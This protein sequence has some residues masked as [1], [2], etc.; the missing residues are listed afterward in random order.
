MGPLCAVLCL[1]IAFRVNIIRVAL[2]VFLG[3]ALAGDGLLALAYVGAL[4]GVLKSPSNMEPLEEL[5]RIAFRVGATLIMFLYLKRS[6]VREKFR[7][8]RGQDDSDDAAPETLTPPR[9]GEA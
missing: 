7:R 8:R 4:A 9:N 6:D 5:M 1:G 2:M 3:I